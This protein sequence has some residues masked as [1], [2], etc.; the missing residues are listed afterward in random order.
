MTKNS[1]SMPQRS[2]R[3]RLLALAAAGGT[4]AAIVTASRSGPV[5]AQSNEPLVG[6][7]ISVLTRTTGDV[8]SALLTF[9]ADGT[10]VNA[11]SDHAA[12]TPSHGHWQSLG[13]GQYAYSVM[14][15]NLDANGKFAG[16]R[17]IDADI[18]MGPTDK[19]WTSTSRTNFYDTLGNFLNSLT[20]TAMANRVPLLRMTDPI[21]Q[22]VMPAS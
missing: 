10:V 7:W 21:P 14:R 6:T 11:T 9:H 2:T 4:A 12:G 22:S 15:I 17:A 19:T 5:L 8:F 13:N 20:S 16:F 3:R 1:D 18:T